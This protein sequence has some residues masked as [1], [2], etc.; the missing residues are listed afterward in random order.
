MWSKTDAQVLVF[1]SSLNATSTL[2]FQAVMSVMARRKEN[3][4]LISDDKTESGA[5]KTNGSW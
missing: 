4:A 2:I 3:D 1:P 5:W